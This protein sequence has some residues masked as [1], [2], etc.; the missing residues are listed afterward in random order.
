[1]KLKMTAL[2]VLAALPF[3]STQAL[4]Q[5]TSATNLEN[6]VFGSV[7]A[8]YYMPDID[9]TE[10]AAWNYMGKDTGYGIE[11]GYYLTEAW[12]IRAEYAKLDLSSELNG[13][14]ADGDRF[15]IDVLYHFLPKAKGAYIL[16]GLKRMDAA[17][18]S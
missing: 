10:S 11:L 15:G 4:A 17:V 3:I 14:D 18:Q 13:S 9:K 2:A 16:G 5:S 8:E 7:F 1:M 6:R 12:A